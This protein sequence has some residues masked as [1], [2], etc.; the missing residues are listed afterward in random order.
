M[1]WAGWA[2]YALMATQG[3]Y[4]TD[5]DLIDQ[6]RL[7]AWNLGSGKYGVTTEDYPF[8][9]AH[10]ENVSFRVQKRYELIELAIDE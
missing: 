8:A 9:K 10:V 6:H 2:F 4:K 5:V 3:M 7:E 1:K